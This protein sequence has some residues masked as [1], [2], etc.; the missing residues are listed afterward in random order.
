MKCCYLTLKP[1]PT[2]RLYIPRF[3]DQDISMWSAPLLQKSRDDE[4]RPSLWL[5]DNEKFYFYRTGRDL[6]K[7]DVCSVDIKTGNVKLLIQERMN[8]YVEIARPW[9][10]N[11]GKELIHWSERDGWAHFYLFDGDGKLK[12][13]ITTG[14]FHCDD[15]VNVDE[16]SRTLYFTAVGREANENPYYT[17]LYSIHFDGSGLHML[18]AGNFTNTAS[19]SDDNK[20]F[21]SNTA[22]RVNTAPKSV[23]YD[24]SGNR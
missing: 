10:V 16:K 14:S 22:S 7:I 2:K 11:G 15:I 4:F 13:Q 19:L 12:N 9:L 24:G 5:G 23:L 17:H 21:V 6:K 8:T 1:K 18:N 20:Y 3:K